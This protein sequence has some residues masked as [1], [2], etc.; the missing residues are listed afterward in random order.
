MENPQRHKNLIRATSI[1][2][3]L[4]L[5]FCKG[6]ESSSKNPGK[7]EVYMTNEN[8]RFLAEHV[9]KCPEEFHYVFQSSENSDYGVGWS[10]SEFDWLVR[11]MPGLIMQDLVEASETQM[12][13]ESVAKS[14]VH[15]ND[16]RIIT[17]NGKT[18]Q[19]SPY[20]SVVIQCLH[21][22]HEKGICQLHAHEVFSKIEEDE[23]IELSNKP[24]I[25]NYFRSGGAKELW[26]NGFIEHERG[27]YW[28][29]IK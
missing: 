10:Q 25:S 21:Q 26:D 13:M 20:A 19:V 29:N 4:Y 24:R 5:C 2:E 15:N 27:F 9:P 11:M 16:Y 3:E 18:Y 8:L 1:I 6:P 22:A 17:W 28:L 23:L 7:I 12:P 14:F